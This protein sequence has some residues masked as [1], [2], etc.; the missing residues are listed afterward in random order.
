MIEQYIGWALVLGLVI[1]GALVWFAVGRIPRGDEE[2]PEPERAAEAVWISEV[3]TERGGIA[4]ES[5]VAE[6][7]DLHVEYVERVASERG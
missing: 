7:L 5:L 4:P 2:I 6:V 1:G 3:I